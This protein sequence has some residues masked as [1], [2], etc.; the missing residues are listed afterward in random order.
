MTERISRHRLQVAE[1]LVAFIE[2]EAL[3]G[4]GADASAF[5]SGF[6]ALVHELAPRHRDL[7]T[8]R[9]QLQA[10]TDAWQRN[11]PGLVADAAAYENFL[12]EIGYLQEQAESV[13]LAARNGDAEFSQ[14]AG[15]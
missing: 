12:R 4:T 9:D 3:P 6:D 15:P 10:R 11:N 1:E 8:H 7:L 14:Q 5:W 2:S 13:S